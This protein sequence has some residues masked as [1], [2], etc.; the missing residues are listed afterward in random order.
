[1]AGGCNSLHVQYNGEMCEDAMLIAL[2]A[3]AKTA[4]DIVSLKF[5]KPQV[6]NLMMMRKITNLLKLT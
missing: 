5:T 2:I 6:G 4:P 1:M 3:I